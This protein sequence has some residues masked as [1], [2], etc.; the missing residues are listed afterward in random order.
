MPVRVLIRLASRF[1][2]EALLVTDVPSKMRFD[3]DAWPVFMP[4]LSVRF[5]SV[6]KKP[7]PVYALVSSFVSAWFTVTWAMVG[8][9]VA[10]I[11]VAAS[12]QM[13][14]PSPAFAPVIVPEKVSGVHRPSS[15]SPAT[16]WLRSMSRKM[17]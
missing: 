8:L 1:T 11:A 3:T 2:S 10:W 15:G 6:E 12:F 13:F 7:M 5:V 4:T 14:P 9:P 16:F 17:M